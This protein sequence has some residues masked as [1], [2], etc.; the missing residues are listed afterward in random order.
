VLDESKIIIDDTEYHSDAN[1]TIKIIENRHSQKRALL[2]LEKLLENFQ[3]KYD[4]DFEHGPDADLVDP[5]TDLGNKPD[6][7]AAPPVAATGL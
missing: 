1:H 6:P 2:D 3:S 7:I 5:T 4:V